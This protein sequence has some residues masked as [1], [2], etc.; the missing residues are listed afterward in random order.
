[1][2]LREYM[3]HNRLTSVELAKQLECS[4]QLITMAKTGKRV[5]KRFA[6]DLERFT[7]GLV[8]VK[9]IMGDEEEDEGGKVA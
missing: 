1:M 9:E 5:S 6:K 8:T 3:F 7:G 4:R 2:N